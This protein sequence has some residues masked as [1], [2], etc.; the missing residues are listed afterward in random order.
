MTRKGARQHV[1]GV[2][3]EYCKMWEGEV[4]ESFIEEEGFLNFLIRKR[5]VNVFCAG[6]IRSSDGAGV[7]L[8][9]YVLP[10]MLAV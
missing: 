10:S 5:R 2:F 3:L 9:D 1:T 4:R 6:K 7:A 8:W